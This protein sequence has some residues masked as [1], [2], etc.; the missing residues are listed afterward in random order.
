MDQEMDLN[1][2]CKYIEVSQKEELPQI[3]EE[4]SDYKSSSYGRG[5]SPS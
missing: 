3:M 5:R 2:I 1:M 4:A